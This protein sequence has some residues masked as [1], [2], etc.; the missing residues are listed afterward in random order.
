[1]AS[2]QN[3]QLLPFSEACERNQRPIL[4]VIGPALAGASNVLEIGSGT[5]QH[6]VFFARHLPQLRWQA[7]ERPQSLNNLA[8]RIAAEQLPNLA[9]PIA[10]DVEDT[11]WQVVAAAVFTANTLHIMSW[12]QVQMLFERLPAVLTGSSASLL[13]YGPFRYAGEFT[14]ASNAEF[15]RLL[16]AHEPLSGIRDF[17]AVDALARSQGLKLLANHSL[18]AN[19][20]LLHWCA[21]ARWRKKC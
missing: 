6:A 14:S 7:S 9:A 21:Q 16:R 12:R 8:Q 4:E 1:M 18:P 13:V 17:E 11:E 15:D 3:S 5:G 2:L 19:N 10:I 20:Q